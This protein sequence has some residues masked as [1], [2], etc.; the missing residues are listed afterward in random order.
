MD[1]MYGRIVVGRTNLAEMAREKIS[2]K[3]VK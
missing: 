1:N 3:I 2:R